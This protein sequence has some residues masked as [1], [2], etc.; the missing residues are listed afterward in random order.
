MFMEV[1]TLD[2]WKQ[3]CSSY[4]TILQQFSS[5]CV[6]K[7][8]T[9]FL[10]LQVYYKDCHPSFPEGGKM[11]QYLDNMALGNTI[12]FRGPSGLLVYEQNGESSVIKGLRSKQLEPADG[13]A[14][15]QEKK[16]SFSPPQAASPSEQIRSQSPKSGS[17]SMLG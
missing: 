2:R 11:S 10:C 4:C 12:D 3:L 15:Q 13:S 9:Y 17:L 5:C 7:A 6:N 1:T 16:A 14:A 8:K